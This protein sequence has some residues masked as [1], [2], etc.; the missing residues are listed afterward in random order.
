MKPSPQRRF[1]WLAALALV[2]LA[3]IAAVA[4][5]SLRSDKDAIEAAAQRELGS[6]SARLVVELENRLGRLP[7]RYGS[8]PFATN[9]EPTIRNPDTSTTWW[10]LDAGGETVDVYFAPEVPTPPSWW[11]EMTEA[12]RDGYRTAVRHAV[13]PTN[14]PA[15][16]VDLPLMAREILELDTNRWNQKLILNQFTGGLSPPL[17]LPSGL[18]F[19]EAAVWHGLKPGINTSGLSYVRAYLSREQPGSWPE[20]SELLRTGKKATPSMV[21]TIEELMR[22]GD[23]R[24]FEREKLTALRRQWPAPEWRSGGRWVTV[25]TNWFLA[26]LDS[27]P[28]AATNDSSAVSLAHWNLTFTPRSAVS[29][30]IGEIDSQLTPETPPFARGRVWLADHVWTL[31]ANNVSQTA[32]PSAGGPF[33]PFR[34]RLANAGEFTGW[35]GY[36][37]ADRSLLL[38]DHRR[39]SWMFGSLI[40]GAALISVLGFWQMQRAFDR[41]QQ[42]A[43]QQ[44]N[45]VSSVS[46]ELRAPVASVGLMVEMLRGDTLTEPARRTEYLRLIARECRRLGQLIQN[47]LATRRLD[48]GRLELAVEPLDLGRLVQETVAGF[49][50]LAT[51]QKVRLELTGELSAVIA[52]GKGTSFEVLGDSLALQQA[53]TNLLDNALKH[54]PPE[55]VITV[56]LRR[57]EPNQLVQLAV[58]DT[59][60]GVPP[61][62]RERIFER[63]YRRGSE[64]RRDTEGIGLG[65]AIVRHTVAAHGGTVWCEAGDQGRGARFV[66]ELPLACP[67]H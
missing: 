5:H 61:T 27:A 67:H 32:P 51:E 60:P 25:S 13:D 15:A 54:S 49:A 18:S 35:A 10:R 56:E 57:M 22:L 20:L 26:V 28:A 44:A 64:L 41:Q 30:L 4:L 38:A 6:L 31:R 66:M 29:A 40:V 59:G 16:T 23:F 34:S 47:V 9:S 45:F 21:S 39:R 63:F 7:V 8:V 36:E 11:L 55:G 58:T 12:Q 2:P 52:D 43:E 50:P 17:L 3:L 48:R 37:I 65:L 42:L 1:R 14:E 24:A 53:L 19:R 46:H 62:D 33:R